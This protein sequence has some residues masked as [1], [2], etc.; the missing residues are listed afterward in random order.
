VELD[1]ARDKVSGELPLGP[2]AGF[3]GMELDKERDKERDKEYSQK[4]SPSAFI[5]HPSSFR[6]VTPP[7]QRPG[8]HRDE[9]AGAQPEIV[10]RLRPAFS[11]R[12]IRS[13][14]TEHDEPGADLSPQVPGEL[15]LPGAGG[16]MT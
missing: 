9:T 2:M 10:W 1:K 15:P 12:E 4:S 11:A 7:G 16:F 14:K 5:P 3:I 13:T 8:F 6:R